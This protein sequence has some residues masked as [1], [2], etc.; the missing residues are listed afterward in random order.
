MNPQGLSI[1][2]VGDELLD[3][4]TFET[5]SHWL[6]ARLAALGVQVDGIEIVGDGLEAIVEALGRAAARSATVLVTGGLGPT[7]DDRTR[8]ALSQFA[9]SPLHFEAGELEEIR[10][11]FEARGRSMPPGN[12]RQAMR[13]QG[14]SFL[15]NDVGTAPGIQLEHGGV[16]FVLMPGVPREMHRMWESSVGGLV[17][18]RIRQER[19]TTLRLRLARS[20]ESAIAAK[21]GSWLADHGDLEV[22]YCVNDWGVDVLMR[23]DDDQRLQKACYELEK[24]LAPRVFH[25]GDRS[26]PELLLDRLRGRAQTLALAES[27]TG[28]LLGATL[29]DV[30]G[31][32]DVLVGAIVAYADQIKMGQLGVP[33][34]LL[35]R[36]GAVSESVALRMAEGACERLRS[37]FALA[38]TG[39]AGPGGGSDEK[40]V[41]TVWIAVASA[42]GAKAELLRLGQDRL[43]NRRQTVA[44]ALDLLRMQLGGGRLDD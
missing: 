5:N 2:A 10:R 43:L 39:V 40:P 7:E 33:A 34:E 23:G 11:R 18:G 20:G 8:E 32:S 22:A 44:A 36:D 16:L 4:R 14:A 28:G 21:V 13:P 27:C 29:T 31:S 41:G 6:L 37:D 26:L 38:T 24:F 30:P 1:L 17:R 12:E 25:V 3:G 19:A 35:E 15:H 42:A 9:G